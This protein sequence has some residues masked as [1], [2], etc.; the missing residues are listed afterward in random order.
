LVVDKFAGEESTF[1]SGNV[2]SHGGQAAYLADINSTSSGTRVAP[3]SVDV[4]AN[5]SSWN[6]VLM[7]LDAIAALPSPPEVLS[8]SLGYSAADLFLKS[9]QL[10]DKDF[11]QN[12]PGVWSDTTKALY[13]QNLQNL[14]SSSQAQFDSSWGGLVQRTSQTMKKLV[15]AGVTVTV[16]A[17]NSGAASVLAKQ[18]G[19]TLPPEFFNGVYSNLPKGVIVVGSTQTNSP[20][21][22]ASNFSSYSTEVDV[23]ADGDD[24]AFKNTSQTFDGTSYSA[25]QVAGLVADML[26]LNRSLTPAQI[27]DIVK[28]SA[29]RIPGQESQVGAGLINREMALQMARNPSSLRTA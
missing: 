10:F 21:T 24:V 15:G 25:P 1:P 22:K 19:L 4:S 13:K 26:V 6:N 8:M 14:V 9:K 28:A 17:G 11:S 23:A 16:S 5:P 29:T 2:S 7:Q 3:L 18:Y 27:D 12:H 20:G